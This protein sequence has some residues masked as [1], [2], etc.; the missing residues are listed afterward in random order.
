[1]LY[2]ALYFSDYVSLAILSF[3]IIQT[4]LGETSYY[5]TTMLFTVLLGSVVCFAYS[6]L[7]VLEKYEA[8]QILQV[9][10]GNFKA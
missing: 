9:E 10:P 4:F 2:T 8:C 1:M 6:F 5:W 3:L 7:Y